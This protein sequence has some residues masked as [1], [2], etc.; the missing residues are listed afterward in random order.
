MWRKWSNSASTCWI[1]GRAPVL[2]LI[3]ILILTLVPAA[4]AADTPSDASEA[5]VVFV[6]ALPADFNPRTGGGSPV[7]T[8]SGFIVAPGKIVTNQHVVADGARFAVLPVRST[9]VYEAKLVWSDPGSDMALLDV[10]NLPGTPLQLATQ[11][12]DKGEK[13]YAF[14]FP[15][16]SVQMQNGGGID[17][18][19]SEGIISSAF[20]RRGWGSNASTTINVLQHTAE[21][22]PGNS[23]GPLFDD[24]DRVIGIN[25]LISNTNQTSARL[26][27]A[28][29]A[30]EL[31]T[32]L[33]QNSPSLALTIAE[34]ACADGKVLGA[35][36]TPGADDLPTEDAD[37]P[38]AD[39][40]DEA[41]PEGLLE[42]FRNEPVWV[43]AAIAGVVLGLL[44]ILVSLLLRGGKT[45][46][47]P[48][49]APA[50]QD[51]QKMRDGKDRAPEPQPGAGPVPAAGAFPGGYRL[52]SADG[53]FDFALDPALLA[54]RQGVA[55][56]RSAA[57]VDFAIADSKISRR[58]C[59]LMWR[60]GT[61]LVEDLDSTAGTLLDG[62][63]LA[64]FAPAVL[65]PGS[66]L[67]LGP[68]T[69]DLVD[70]T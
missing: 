55:I 49:P 39:E 21:V 31:L 10:P 43:R 65:R 61:L 45:V 42:R 24:C 29:R 48:A 22:S 14:G 1:E 53:A 7:S 8:G 11:A 67:G 60:E 68:I 62:R 9:Q 47:R 6:V 63:P 37:E 59:R 52:R 28:S 32:R 2:R 3:A 35:A 69:L 38:A 41:A 16:A 12:P 13:V 33:R 17:S 15:G 30:D 51:G 27:F 40:T 50:V 64:P 66:R 19:L 54:E 26:S 5:A 56:G 46:D 44:G 58:H 20:A 70:R 34:G 18:S 4:A 57:F 36:A 25:T 23:G